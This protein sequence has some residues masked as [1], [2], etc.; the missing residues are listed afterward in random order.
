MLPRRFFTLALPAATISASN[1]LSKDFTIFSGA[2]RRSYNRSLLASVSRLVFTAIAE[3]PLTDEI[4]V[5]DGIMSDDCRAFLASGCCPIALGNFFD[6]FAFVFFFEIDSLFQR[7]VL[8][9][10]FTDL[11]PRRKIGICDD[12][13]SR[14]FDLSVLTG[15]VNQF[16]PGSMSRLLASVHASAQA[17][18]L[19]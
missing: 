16:K 17:A 14:G 19:R 18:M 4:S 9:T 13:L 8:S 1:R 11:P 15:C 12:A 3:D 5:P 7:L 6:L 2:F 10:I